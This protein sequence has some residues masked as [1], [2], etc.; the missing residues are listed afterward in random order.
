[1]IAGVV[2]GGIGTGLLITIGLAT[3]TVRW[4]AYL[5]ITGI[6]IGMGIQLPYTA[7]QVVLR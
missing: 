2:L 7:V 6:G 1:M 3:T 5:V 4:A